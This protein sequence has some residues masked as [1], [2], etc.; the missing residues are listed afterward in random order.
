[1]APG[2]RLGGERTWFGAAWAGMIAVGASVRDAVRT[3]DGHM[4]YDNQ[5]ALSGAGMS[6]WL[7][8]PGDSVTR[9]MGGHS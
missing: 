4:D 9:M 5:M 7:P 6:G 3:T 8:W 2:E 1:M